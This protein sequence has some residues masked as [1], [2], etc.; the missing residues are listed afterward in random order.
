MHSNNQKTREEN[1]STLKSLADHTSVLY[2]AERRVLNTWVCSD[3]PGFSVGEP[4]MFS[5]PLLLD[6]SSSPFLDTLE[7]SVLKLPR[8]KQ[9]NGFVFQTS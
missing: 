6:L 9:I 7:I 2:L 8:E 5:L 4:R 3:S 1:L